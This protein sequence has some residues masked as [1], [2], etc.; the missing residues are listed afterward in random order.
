M[1]LMLSAGRSGRHVASAEGG[2][3]PLM[4]RWPANPVTAV[5]H[6][7]QAYMV[8]DV[9]IIECYTAASETQ[10]G[11]CLQQVRQPEHHPPEQEARPHT[12]DTKVDAGC[13]QALPWAPPATVPKRQNLLETYF[14]FLRWLMA[15]PSLDGKMIWAFCWQQSETI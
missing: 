3:A 11:L 2:W 14:A 7:S 12:P 15:G 9:C 6:V 5:F 1:R 8:P 13:E 10:A 4:L